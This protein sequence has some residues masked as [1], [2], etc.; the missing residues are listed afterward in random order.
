MGWFSNLRDQVTKTVEKA[1]PQLIEA[2]TNYLTGGSFAVNLAPTPPPVS[3]TVDKPM[4]RR[5]VSV[6]APAAAVNAPP[7]TTANEGMGFFKNKGLIIAGGLGAAL[8]LV[9]FAMK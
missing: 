8:L 7:T 3:P 1:A 9:L 4:K 5:P 2:G 6:S